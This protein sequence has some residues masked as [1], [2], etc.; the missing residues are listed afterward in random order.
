MSNGPPEMERRLPAPSMLYEMSLK[1]SLIDG[2]FF[3]LNSSFNVLFVFKVI[4]VVFIDDFVFY[5]HSFNFQ[6]RAGSLL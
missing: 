6:V 1:M 5:L 3:F 4:S 2:F